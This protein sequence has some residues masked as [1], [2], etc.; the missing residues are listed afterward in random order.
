MGSVTRGLASLAI[1][2][3]FA[4]APS[5]APAQP[6]ALSCGDR[7]TQDTK[8]TADLDCSGLTLGSAVIVAAD[9][10]TLNLNG[11]TIRG[12]SDPT[13]VSTFGVVVRGSGDT[14]MGGTVSGFY[15]DAFASGGGPPPFV[16][17]ATFQ[18]LTLTDAAT[19]ISI[20]GANSAAVKSNLINA[21]E[22]GIDY[23][24]SEGGVFAAN[25]ITARG[26][27]G[28]PS[29]APFGFPACS[30]IEL[31]GGGGGALV[32]GNAIDSGGRGI[33]VRFRDSPD[34]VF[35]NT[36]TC[37][38]DCIVI[39]GTAGGSSL[40]RNSATA[41]TG[42]SIRIDG[43]SGYA[44]RRNSAGGSINASGIVLSNVNDSEVADNT[45]NGNGRFGLSVSGAAN[46]I[47]G[48]VADGNGL[49][50]I[51]SVGTNTLTANTARDNGGSG[52]DALEGAIDGGRNSASGNAEPQC[53]GVD[54]SP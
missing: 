47:K 36:A 45:A 18:R 28:G 13:N 25:T 50:G 53:V 38:A 12:P 4:V 33:D 30:G 20:Y 49:D 11:H 31:S 8:L 22:R 27:P 29:C 16:A 26:R 2:A 21:V 46:M 6:T 19:G 44:V 15:V 17:E 48:N 10:V 42:A 7:I 41:T 52:I 1:V 54:C 39:G 43:G 32:R 3:S 24:N 35:D 34:T 5:A 40:E 14:V 9:D 51:L 37:V 23:S